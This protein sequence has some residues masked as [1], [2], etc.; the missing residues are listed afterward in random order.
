VEFVEE[1]AGFGSLEFGPATDWRATADYT[2]L[3]LDLGGSAAGNQGP[4]VFL[5]GSEGDKVAVGLYV[6]VSMIV[7]AEGGEGKNTKS[8]DRKS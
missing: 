7:M 2:V 6:V 1:L 8:L 5:E 4:E 3:C